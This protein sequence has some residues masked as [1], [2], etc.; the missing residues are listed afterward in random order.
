MK[1]LRIVHITTVPVTLGFFRGQIG[2][3]KGQGFEVIAITSPGDL[4]TQFANDYGIEIHEIPMT[5]SISPFRDSFSLIRLWILLRR[6]KP[7]L[8]HSHTPKAA[9]LG[10]LAARAAGVRV[11]FLSIFGLRQMTLTGFKKRLLDFTTRLQNWLA[12]RVVFDSFSL[13]DYSVAQG[14]CR[15]AKAVVFG[16]GSVSGIDAEARF[17]PAQYPVRLR[18]SIRTRY[19]IPSDALVIGFTGRIAKDKGM[20]ELAKAWRLLSAEFPNL[21]LLLVGP[22]ESQDPISPEDEALFR[23]DPRIVLTGFVTDTVALYA[24]MDIYV[25]P[26]YREGFSL[27]NIEAAAMQLPVVSTKIFGCVDSVLDGV[28]GTLVPS[29]DAEAL[30]AA[31]SAY[32]HDADLRRVHASA[33][34]ARIQRDF[35]PEL[36]WE[37]SYTAYCQLLEAK[38]KRLPSRSGD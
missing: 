29:H 6:L 12:D 23:S 26:S 35:R 3:L 13:R 20:R 22:M 1:P 8:V 27:S 16:K 36:I 38:G 4:T 21:Y 24:I 18:E 33:G 28:T 19:G 30:A 15:D 10:T 5:R 34:R 17:N 25:L 7:D 2:Y 37:A 9:L 32:L 11:V 31:L 14:Y